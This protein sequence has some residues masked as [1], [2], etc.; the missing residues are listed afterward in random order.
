MGCFGAKKS[1][2]K[3]FMCF[4]GPQTVSRNFQFDPVTILMP[5]LRTSVEWRAQSIKG[6]QQETQQRDDEAPLTKGLRILAA[7]NGQPCVTAEIRLIQE[8]QYR[9]MASRAANKFHQVGCVF[10]THN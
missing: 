5:M 1:M 4:F 10:F 6:R 2:L 3:R 8:K 7:R 9:L